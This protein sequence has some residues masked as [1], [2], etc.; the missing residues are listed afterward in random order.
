M[1]LEEFCAAPICQLF[2]IFAPCQ[3]ARSFDGMDMPLPTVAIVGRPNVGKSSL[4]NALS[5]SD[6]AIVSAM[7]GTT[8]DVLSTTVDIDGVPVVCQDAAGF[9]EASGDLAAAADSAAR[10]AVAGAD[11]VCLVVDAAGEAA[12]DA[13]LLAELRRANAAEPM[14]LA[15]KIDLVANAAE[16]VGRIAGALGVEP[17]ATSAQTGEGLDELRRAVAERLHVTASRGGGGLGLHRRQKRCLVSAAAAVD[18]AAERLADCDG[19]ADQA[20]WVAVDLREALSEVGRISGE[21]VTEDVLGQIFS[22]F[23]VGK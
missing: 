17:I 23:C 6:R 22:R 18:R 7:A 9:V 14:V 11:V 15:N 3:P 16:A 5:G 12:A 8:R 2:L 21:V 20:E 4:L 19:L 1:R 10:S 13:A